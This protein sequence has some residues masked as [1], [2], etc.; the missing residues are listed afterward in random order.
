MSIARVGSDADLLAIRELFL[1]YAASLDV[2]LAYQDFSRE[3]AELP[4]EYAAPRGCLFIATSGNRSVG[5]VAVRPADGDNCEMK[6]LYI[7]PAA[8]GSG[9]GELTAES[10]IAFARAAGY[11][12]MRL[13]TGFLNSE[14]LTLYAGL[15][16]HERDAYADY[17]PQIAV[18]L[19]FMERPL[20]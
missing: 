17:P 5:C 14:A 20:P 19:R 1:E 11:R 6:R 3:V 9:L 10:A 15:G 7:R 4:G 18:H 2:D 12:A 16:F 8:R 13:D